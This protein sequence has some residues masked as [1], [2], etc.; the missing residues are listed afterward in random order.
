MALKFAIDMTASWRILYEWMCAFRLFIDYSPLRRRLI[1]NL[2][3][4]TLKHKLQTNYIEVQAS[5]CLGSLLTIVWHQCWQ[6][7]ANE[8][9]LLHGTSLRRSRCIAMKGLYDRLVSQ[10]FYGL[11]IYFTTELCN[12]ARRQ[13]WM[14]SMAWP[15]VNDVGAKD[16]GASWTKLQQLSSL[17]RQVAAEFCSCLARL[18]A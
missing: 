3:T 17:Q 16:L 15:N 8:V 5:S 1:F 2:W 18:P 4:S 14:V 10:D 12:T 9:L 6:K 7:S 11:G 13:T